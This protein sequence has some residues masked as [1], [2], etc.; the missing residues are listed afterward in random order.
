MSHH[1]VWRF[2]MQTDSYAIT[3]TLLII[4]I[5]GDFQTNHPIT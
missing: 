4:K 3:H 5:K 2:F 1:Y